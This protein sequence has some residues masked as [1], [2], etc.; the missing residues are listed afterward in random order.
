MTE[1]CNGRRT[2]FHNHRVKPRGHERPAVAEACET[3]GGKW[4]VWHS[5]IPCPDCNG[6]GE[7]KEADGGE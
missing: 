2:P 7:R 4:W 3:C 6:T 1:I 5:D